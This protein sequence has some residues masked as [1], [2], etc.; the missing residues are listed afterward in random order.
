[1]SEENKQLALRHIEALNA[2]DAETLERLTH[3]DFFDHAVQAAR[4]IEP[5]DIVAED[6]RVVV[7]TR[8]GVHIWRF[9]DG[10]IVEHWEFDGN[11]HRGRGT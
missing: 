10:R 4:S 3:P 7:R 11:V 9:S 1:V 8:T 2:G 5:L 6:D